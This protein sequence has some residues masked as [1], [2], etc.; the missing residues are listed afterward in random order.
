MRVM[1]LHPWDISPREAIEIQRR[2]RSRLVLEDDFISI[3]LI[4][5]CDI[6]LDPAHGMSY[7]GV[8]VYSFPD[9]R[10][11]ERKMA[12]RKI[13][14]PYIPGLLAFR[15]APVL[16]ESIRL[17]N[18]E[19][20]LFIFDGQGIAHPRG[21]GIAS[22]MG[23]LVDRP[24]IG[25]A[26]SRLYG[27]YEEPGREKGSESPLTTRDSGIIGS[28]VRTRTDVQPIFVSQGHRISLESAVRI[29]L[30]CTDGVRVPK[31]TREADHLVE[32]AKRIDLSKPPSQDSAFSDKLPRGPDTSLFPDRIL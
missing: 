20:D 28:V 32:N 11:V 2:L 29:T 10:E 1:D 18:A 15:E 13:A 3:R 16:I 21:L 5:G 22:H 19:P 23:L 31:P 17:L 12:K 26:K 6:S 27:L 9:L 14:F 4:A 24:A 25:C 7:G 8:I 30:Q